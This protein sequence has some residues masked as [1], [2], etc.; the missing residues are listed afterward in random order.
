VTDRR[1][2]LEGTFEKH[3]SK[4]A[5]RTHMNITCEGKKTKDERKCRSS[6]GTVWGLPR[7]RATFCCRPLPSL[8]FHF[9]DSKFSVLSSLV[10]TSAGRLLNSAARTGTG[11]SIFLFFVLFFGGEFLH[12]GF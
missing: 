4:R 5:R 7:K 6:V 9:L 2:T 8:S 12:L 3:A 1:E 10:H 11:I